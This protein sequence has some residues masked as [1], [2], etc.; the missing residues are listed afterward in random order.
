MKKILI[1]LLFLAPFS[2]SAFDYLD[3]NAFQKPSFFNKIWECKWRISCYQTKFGAFT[4]IASTDT[5]TNFPTTYNA[6]LTKTIEVGTTS[7]ASI[8]TLAN[9]ESIGTIITGIWNGTVIGV[10]YNGTGTTSPTTNQVML[11]NGSSGFKVIGFG[12]SGQ[13]LTSGG[14][15][16]APSWTVG[17][18][19]Q[20]QDYNF[21]GTTFRVKNLHASSTSA[22][23]IVLNT[24]S[25]NTPSAQGA[26]STTL[27]ND[28][29]G[30]LSWL[31]F[32]KKLTTLPTINQNC[33]TNNAA[34]TTIYSFAIPANTLG[35]TNGVRVRTNLI[36]GNYGADIIWFD[37]GYGNASTTA[38]LTTTSAFGSGGG[39]IEVSLLANGAT[40]SQRLNMSI[41][42][43]LTGKS[44]LGASLS[45]DSTVEKRLT[46]VSRSI[47]NGPLTCGN[48]IAEIIQ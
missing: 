46:L 41:V 39:Y 24:I 48:T 4:T 25:Y 43:A 6:N 12:T 18:V 3:V 32:T 2:A 40:N 8:T 45:Q 20:T 47:A 33:S 16:T 34:S 36:T 21:T 15:A 35:T 22:N 42:D 1:L 38:F 10:A 31:G 28:G 44:A 7:V 13:F 30:N 26:A 23:P 37:V 19:D 14:D 5:L 17:T 27:Q 29:A 9:L 11:G